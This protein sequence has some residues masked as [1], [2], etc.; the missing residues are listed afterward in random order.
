MKKL[1]ILLGIILF[2]SGSLYSMKRD[3]SWIDNTANATKEC[4]FDPFPKEIQ[5]IISKNLLNTFVCKLR[6]D[7]DQK[8]LERYAEETPLCLV[9]KFASEFVQLRN[10]CKQRICGKWFSPEQLFCLSQQE[11]DAFISTANRPFYMPGNI[12]N[13]DYEIIKKIPQKKLTKE[14][15]LEIL[16]DD[17]ASCCC[18]ATI[19]IARAINNNIVLRIGAVPIGF[20]FMIIFL[21][22]KVLLGTTEFFLEQCDDG[23]YSIK[24]IK[25]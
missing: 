2:N 13:A 9:S 24:T 11:R 19:R 12:T 6:K 23:K 4:S 22:G 21:F 17:T 20:P 1:I 3:I 25:L 8:R 15:Q 16:P 5:V 14:M 7:T 10:I 18:N